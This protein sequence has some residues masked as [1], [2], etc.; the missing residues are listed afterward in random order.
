M[1]TYTT[2]GIVNHALVLCGASPITAL[3]DDSANARSAN[4]IYENARKQFLTE[5]QWTFN[6]TRSTLVTNS[7]ASLFP[8]TF[9]EEGY[10]YNRP[11][12]TGSCLR[13][14]EV[15]VRGAVWREEGDYIVSDTSGLGMRWAWDNS[16]V[17]TWRPSAVAAFMDK[18][19]MDIAYMILNSVEKSKMFLEKY[20]KVSLPAA[21]AENS[22][23]GEQQWV[24]D[25]YW[26]N[27]RLGMGGNPGRS[28]S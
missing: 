18:L 23:T 2:V 14:W 7:T 17:G 13:I 25:D 4:A 9:D 15:S 20:E 8:W 6:T 12:T 19:C 10:F 24:M 16:E 21:M 1:A 5:C 27:S 22:Q 26:T 3:S 11:G 28:Y